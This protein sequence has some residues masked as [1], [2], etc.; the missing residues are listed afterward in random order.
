[1]PLHSLHPYQEF[2]LEKLPSWRHCSFT[3]DNTRPDEN[4]VNDIETEFQAA[5]IARRLRHFSTVYFRRARE[6][7]GRSRWDPLVYDILA[8]AFSRLVAFYLFLIRRQ[9]TSLAVGGS[10]VMWR[11]PPSLLGYARGLADEMEKNRKRVSSYY[12]LSNDKPLA[13]WVRENVR[14]VIES[15]VGSSAITPHAHIRV[16][17]TD[18][19]SRTWEYMYRDHPYGYYHWDE[20]CYS[21]PLIVYLDDVT[22]WDGPYSYV[23]GSDKVPQNLTIRAFTQAISCKLL[24]TDNIDDS[25]KRKIAALPRIFRGGEMVGSHVDPALFSEQVVRRVTGIAGTATLSDGFSLVHG[26]GHPS[27]GRR[28]ALFIAHR[29]PRKRLL[30]VGVAISRKWWRLQMPRRGLDHSNPP[31]NG[32]AA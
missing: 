3:N 14:P 18:S 10:S 13:A 19:Y 21:I 6:I 12:P 31:A 8:E 20:L 26:G 27:A 24:V 30:D 7:L 5:L 9:R 32:A 2:D 29:Y 16:V 1:V 25:H 11:I 23:E 28:R 15:Y 22:V 4:A 17:S